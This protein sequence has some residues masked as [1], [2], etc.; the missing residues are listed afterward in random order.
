MARRLAIGLVIASRACAPSPPRTRT[1][2]AARTLQRAQA[3]V[4]ASETQRERGRRQAG[5][6]GRAGA[7]GVVCLAASEW[8]PRLQAVAPAHGKRMRLRA[9]SVDKNA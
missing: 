9:V 3:G 8:I 2:Y 5:G 7:V 4:N 6:G 1:P